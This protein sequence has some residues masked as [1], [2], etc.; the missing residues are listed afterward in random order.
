MRSTAFPTPDI[1]LSG[2]DEIYRDNGRK[3]FK[4]N[5]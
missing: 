4:A 5:S 3:E 1:Q 2:E